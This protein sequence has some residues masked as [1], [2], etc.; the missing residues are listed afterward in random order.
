[1]AVTAQALAGCGGMADLLW[2]QAW[3]T[4]MGI[5]EGGCPCEAPFSGPRAIAE[6][7]PLDLSRKAR[8]RLRFRQTFSPGAWAA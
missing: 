3:L 7:G 8:M 5:F 1:M 4:D 6:T 2:S